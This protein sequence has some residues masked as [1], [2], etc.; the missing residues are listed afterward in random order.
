MLKLT[1]FKVLMIGLGLTG[2]L[3]ATV[4]V[5][6]KEPHLLKPINKDDREKSLKAFGTVM[7]VI[8][9]PRCINC[10]PTNDIPRQGNAHRLHPFNV[11]RG[12]DDHGGLVQ[13]CATCHHK[14]NNSY[15]NVPGAPHWGLAPKTMGWFGLTDVEIA[16]A[17][18]DK[19]KNG[20][21]SPADLVKHMSTDS[22]VLWAWNPGKG[23]SA[24]PV[25]VDEFRKALEEWLE[26]GAHIPDK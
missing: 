16:H 12:E 19:S 7:E 9:S 17:L 26:T 23:R 25:P 2:M 20:G 1:F 10:H 24:P 22:L 11:N 21:R 6:N 13:K 3:N 5:N 18:L 14:E 4:L 15:T 8:K